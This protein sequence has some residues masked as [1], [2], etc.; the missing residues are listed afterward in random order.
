[1]LPRRAG[2]GRVWDLEIAHCAWKGRTRRIET[3]LGVLSTASLESRADCWAR[4]DE[5]LI[6][7]KQTRPRGAALAG[8]QKTT[9]RALVQDRHSQFVYD[10]ATDAGRRR[11]SSGMANSNLTKD[12]PA[13]KRAN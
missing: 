2:V 5:K 9:K 12:P 6:D 3:G 1:M 8:W 10:S 4:R 13:S 11:T 7:R